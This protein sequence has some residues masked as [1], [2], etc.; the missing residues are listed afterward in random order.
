MYT[1]I[2]YGVCFSFSLCDSFA[3]AYIHASPIVFFLFFYLNRASNVSAAGARFYR[4]SKCIF[5][6]VEIQCKCGCDSIFFFFFF[7]SKRTGEH[8]SVVPQVDACRV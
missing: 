5:F 8:V 1:R 4:E 7:F 3:Y 6:L 2:G